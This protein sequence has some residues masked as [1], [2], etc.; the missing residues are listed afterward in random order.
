MKPRLRLRV[1]RRPCEDTPALEAEAAD[2]L[3][4]ALAELFVSRARASV[5]AELGLDDVELDA[6]LDAG[7][8]GR[9]ER[10]R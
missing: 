4:A 5:A 7:R 6:N 3:A 8:R 1:E 10:R 9:R 2:L